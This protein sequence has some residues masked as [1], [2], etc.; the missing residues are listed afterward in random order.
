MGR[1]GRMRILWKS[2][3]D[4]FKDG[5]PMLTG[6]IAYFFLMS[7]IPFCL[8]LI[9]LLGYFIGENASFYNFFATRLF[10]LF[11]SATSQIVDELRALVVYRKI[12]VLTF[13]IYAYFSYQLFFALENAIHIIFQEKSKSTIGISLIKSFLTVT[14]I[15]ALILVSFALTLAIQM[16]KSLITLKTVLQV[17]ILMRFLIQFAIPLL[18]IFLVATLFYLMLPLRRVRIR[19]ALAGALFTVVFLQI[20]RYLF[21]SAAPQIGAIYASLSGFVIFLFWIFY[22]AAIFLIGAEIVKNLGTAVR[23]A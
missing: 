11:P 20:A 14:I 15:A 17:G 12:G 8:L 10:K 21:S 13:F 4:F 5:G 1:L 16:L 2:F 6:S 19:H 9:T 22:A 23:R 7:F 3:G 18:L